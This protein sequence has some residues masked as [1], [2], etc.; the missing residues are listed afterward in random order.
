MGY[1]LDQSMP[2]NG[3]ESL[4]GNGP[5]KVSTG[6]VGTCDLR[7]SQHSKFHSQHPKECTSV[8]MTSSIDGLVL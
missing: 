2:M 7:V 5:N 6:F 1:M 3:S 4:L 8:V